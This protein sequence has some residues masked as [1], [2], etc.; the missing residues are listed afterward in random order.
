VLSCKIWVCK[1]P[2]ILLKCSLCR[3]ACWTDTGRQVTWQQ[4]IQARENIVVFWWLQDKPFF[5]LI[6]HT[7]IYIQCFRKV[8]VHLGYGT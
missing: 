4:G 3:T 2:V 6:F 1:K 8:A 7:Q 5:I